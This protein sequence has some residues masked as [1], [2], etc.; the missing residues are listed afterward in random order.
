M[1]FFITSIKTSDVFAI[2]VESSLLLRYGTLAP[3]AKAI[4]A[5]SWLSVLTI[6]SSIN[7]HFLANRILQS[8]KGLPLKGSIF[9]SLIMEPDLA[10]I[11][12]I[13]LLYKVIF[14]NLG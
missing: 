6:Q 5:I 7:L 1:Q 12:D 4:S 14:K 13:I 9:Y 10:G 3:E 8:I 11:I 2:S